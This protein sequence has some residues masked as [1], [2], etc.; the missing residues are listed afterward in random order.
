MGLGRMDAFIE[1]VAATVAKDDEGFATTTDTV[2]AKVRAYKEDRQGRSRERRDAGAAFSS[3]TTL[4]R[5]RTIPS[6]NITTAH[7]IRCGGERYTIVSVA[8]MRGMY[9]EVLAESVMP[10]GGD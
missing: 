8:D 6:L 4:F 5:F 2:L 3:A 1:I 7:A 10:K 9:V